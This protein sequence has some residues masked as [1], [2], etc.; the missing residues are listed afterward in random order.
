MIGQGIGIGAN[1][2]SMIRGSQR[3]TIRGLEEAREAARANEVLDEQALAYKLQT[4]KDMGKLTPEMEQEILQEASG[5]NYI[6]TDPALREAQMAALTNMERRGREGL[7]LEDRA[8]AEDINR[9]IQ[10]EQ[11]AGNEAVLQNMQARGQLGSGGE[12]AA[13]L[14]ASQAGADQARQ[15]GSDL[16]RLAAA[17]KLQATMNAGQMGGDIRQQEF[18]EQSQKAQAQDLINRFNTSSKQNVQSANVGEKNQ[19][20]RYNLDYSKDLE[21]NRV[22][23]A[24]EQARINANAYERALESRNLKRTGIANI[25]KDI[26]AQK[27]IQFG[28]RIQSAA[29][30]G[31]T[32]GSMG[33]NSMFGGSSA[34][35]NAGTAGYS[36]A[37]AYQPSQG[38]DADDVKRA[39]LGMRPR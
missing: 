28:N 21:S 12:L 7:T 9:G 18:G 27:D 13:K 24:N 36:Q 15:Q 1:L 38:A 2:A 5:M 11:R 3:S 39:K 29:K 16:A 25:G 10:Q 37:N 26:G 34:P 23:T 19:A 32:V 22:G 4:L 35:A 20:N 14:S 30:I 31:D 8:A 17:Q 6:S 33:T